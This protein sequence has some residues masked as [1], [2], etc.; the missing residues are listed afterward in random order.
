M[1]VTLSIPDATARRFRA[2]VPSR[3]RSQVV[4]HLIEQELAKRDDALAAACRAANGD[5]ALAREIDEW[6]AFDD[7]LEE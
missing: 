3:R 4:A 2:A 7:G 5:A 1:R 6:Q